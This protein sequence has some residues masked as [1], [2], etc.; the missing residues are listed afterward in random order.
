[1]YIQSIYSK[2]I[3]ICVRKGKP[4][5]GVYFWRASGASRSSRARSFTFLLY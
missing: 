3:I 2:Y 5:R 4:H 1:M